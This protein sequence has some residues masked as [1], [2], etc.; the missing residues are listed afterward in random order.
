MNPIPA[1]SPKPGCRLHRRLY[2]G[3][4]VAAG[5]LSAAAPANAQ[6]GGAYV[7]KKSTIDGGGVTAAAGGAYVS[8]GTVGQPDAVTIAGGVYLLY[9]GFWSPASLAPDMPSPETPP[10]GKVRHLSF[11]VPSTSLGTSTALRVELT[12][13]HHPSNPPPGT[14]NFAAFEGQFRYVN[15]FFGGT[16]CVDSITFESYYRCG[17]L[18][19]EP[20]YRDWAADLM[21]PTNPPSQAGLIH[22]T[23]E[24]VVPSSTYHVSH[25]AAACGSAP[26]ANVCAIASAPFAVSTSRWGDVAGSGGGPPDGLQNVLDIGQVVDNVKAISTSLPEVRAWLKNPTNVAGVSVNVVDIGL[27]VDSVKGFAYPYSIPACP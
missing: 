17:R 5:A 6:S 7:I 24:M 20:E 2:A 23:G 27:V 26:G 21:E 12:S 18:G 19:C 4:L 13:L 25:I 22:V 9:G 11:V 15:S 3:L 14:P 1:P 10:L 16:L 8:S